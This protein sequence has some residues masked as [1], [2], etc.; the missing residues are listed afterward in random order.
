MASPVT[1]TATKV[2]SATKKQK[3]HKNNQ[4]QIHRNPPF[5]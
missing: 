1:A 5:E 3:K 2:S 4:E